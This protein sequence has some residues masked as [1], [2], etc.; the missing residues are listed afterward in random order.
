MN[1]GSDRLLLSLLLALTACTILSPLEVLAAGPTGE[2]VTRQASGADDRAVYSEPSGSHR[3]IVAVAGKQAG[4]GGART[5]EGRPRDDIS[6]SC[7]T[8]RLARSVEIQPAT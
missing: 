5:A 7:S 2:P 1:P 6:K 8:T 3:A 4:G